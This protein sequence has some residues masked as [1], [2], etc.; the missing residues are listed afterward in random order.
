MRPG[1]TYRGERRNQW[2]F[3]RQFSSMPWRE[4]TAKFCANDGWDIGGR[5]T[6][7]RGRSLPSYYIGAGT[8]R[9]KYMPHNGK[10]EME[11]RRRQL[12]A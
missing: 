9:S 12:A 11:R 10:R 3:G 2:A 5:S 6:D 8:S 1:I 4:W 7:R